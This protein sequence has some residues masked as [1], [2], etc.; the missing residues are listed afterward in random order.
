M[1]AVFRTTIL[2]LFSALLLSSCS[3]APEISARRA[4]YP[5]SLSESVYGPDYE[6]LSIEEGALDRLGDFSRK[7]TFYK[8]GL[9]VKGYV[10]D[11]HWDISSL[12]N[13]EVQQR[14]G[15]AV[16]RLAIDVESCDFT[17]A[18]LYFFPLGLLAAVV[19]LIPSCTDVTV[20]GTVVKRADMADRAD[21]YQARET[22]PA[23]PPVSYSEQPE[24][25]SLPDSGASNCLDLC[26]SALEQAKTL[27]TAETCDGKM[28]LVRNG[29]KTI[30]SRRDCGIKGV[31]LWRE[32]AAAMYRLCEQLKRAHTR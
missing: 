30:C 9:L 11:P 32:E 28:T 18:G 2:A 16:V 26:A 22:M 24:E 19:P 3:G 20:R 14:Q 25:A 8:M 15:E 4:R 23:E 10:S 17:K 21:P 12:I 7:R 6:V 13:R 31:N 27:L 5:V 29:V 1:K